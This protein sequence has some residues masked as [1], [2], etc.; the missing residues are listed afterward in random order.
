MLPELKPDD[1]S[2]INETSNGVRSTATSK[3]ARDLAAVFRYDNSIDPDHRVH[4]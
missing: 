2:L 1:R 3:T 4:S